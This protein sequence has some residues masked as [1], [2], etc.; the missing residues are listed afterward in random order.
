MRKIK[1]IVVHCSATLSGVRPERI[2]EIH[3][4]PVSCGGRGWRNPG[5]HYIIASDG[6]VFQALS[7]D[8]IANGAKGYN[9]D[10]LHIC[11]V[12]GLTGRGKYTDTRTEIQR[13]RMRELIAD[14]RKKY[15]NIAVVGHR[16]LSKD[17]NGDGKISRDEWI[18]LCPCFDVATE[19]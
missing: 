5:Y 18:K 12:G 15:G 14:L 17:L 2:V 3:R 13:K 19:L 16:D 11:Y 6:R 7:E 8:G 1:R 10:S 9:A 4:L